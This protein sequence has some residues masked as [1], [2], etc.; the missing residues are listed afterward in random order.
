MKTMLIG[1]LLTALFASGGWTIARHWWTAAEGN[2]MVQVT[3]PHTPPRDLSARVLERLHEEALEHFYGDPQ[4]GRF[5]MPIVY[6]QVVRDW[7]TPWFSPGDL[8]SDE[9]VPFKADMERIHSGSV[10]DFFKPKPPAKPKEVAIAR[11]WTINEISGTAFDRNKK[12]WEAKSVELVGLLNHEHPV[13]YIAETLADMHRTQAA[14]TRELDDFEAAGL[15]ALQNGQDLFARS[16][17]GVIRLMGSVRARN[18][19]ANGECLACHVEKKEGDLLGAFSYTLRPA[20][21]KG[22]PFHMSKEFKERQQQQQ[23]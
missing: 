13:V 23:Q 3:G 6:E 10:K 15:V 1:G 20:E 11:A 4:N 7:Q 8:E 21:Y 14:K 17:D 18:G 16:R 2:P 22:V 19:C 5:R 12:V 9:P